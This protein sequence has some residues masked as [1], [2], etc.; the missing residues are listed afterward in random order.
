M[1]TPTVTIG[2]RVDVPLVQP[3]PIETQALHLPAGS[4]MVQWVAHCAAALRMCW[5]DG[6]AWPLLARPPRWT[7]SRPV[8]D[9]GAEVYDAL[10]RGGVDEAEVIAAGSTAL[11]FA[12]GL[13]QVTQSEVKAA[14]GFSGPLAATASAGG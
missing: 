2:P 13:P 7:L 1:T 8:A 4:P 9:F 14:E 6:A 5:P 10:I 3:R 12:L 11:R